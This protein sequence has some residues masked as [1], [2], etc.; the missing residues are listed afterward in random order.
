[1]VVE[2]LLIRALLVAPSNLIAGFTP[3]VG[4]SHSKAA[5]AAAKVL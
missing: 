5:A 2:A 3:T 4:A 1:M